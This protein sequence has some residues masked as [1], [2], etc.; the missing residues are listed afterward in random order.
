M[1]NIMLI[2]SSIRY[3]STNCVYYTLY[4]IFTFEKQNVLFNI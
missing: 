1:S 2:C 3:L 4:N